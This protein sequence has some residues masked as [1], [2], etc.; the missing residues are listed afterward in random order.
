[1]SLKNSI[2]NIAYNLEYNRFGNKATIQGK[3]K[4]LK[5]IGV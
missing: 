5:I 3:L 1:M 2:I 4:D